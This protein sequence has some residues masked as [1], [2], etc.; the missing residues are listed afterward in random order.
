MSPFKIVYGLWHKMKH[1]FKVLQRPKND[2]FVFIFLLL[3]SYD[4]VYYKYESLL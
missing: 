2:H 1:K 4:N 3:A